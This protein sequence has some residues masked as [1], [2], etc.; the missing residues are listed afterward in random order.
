M[1]KTF[2][3]FAI[4]AISMVA[5]TG[6]Q[7]EYSVNTKSVSISSDGSYSLVVTPSDN[8]WTFESNNDLIASVSSTGLI[9]ANY[10]GNTSIVIKNAANN[11]TATCSVT[12]TPK[13]TMYREPYLNFGATKSNVKAYETRSLYKE[14]TGSLTFLGENSLI[15][16]AIYLFENSKLV[17]SGAQI[18]T[19]YASLLGSFCGER[20][21]Y[22]YTSEDNII[23]MIS[24]DYKMIVGIEVVDIYDIY[25]VYFKNTY[26]TQSADLSINAFELN[27]IASKFKSIKQSIPEKERLTF[28]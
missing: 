13:Y 28:R 4:M 23:T 11:F 6:C 18:P 20:Y 21:V 8:G 5:L 19:S 3:L 12:V 27:E 14:E 7:E 16:S 24:P 10:V 22:L 15:T 1:K 2:Y 17:C 9:T 25:V 26:I